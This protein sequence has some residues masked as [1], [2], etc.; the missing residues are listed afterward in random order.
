M[1]PECSL[2]CSQEP[3]TGPYP[4]PDQSSP[5]H[6]ILSLSKIHFNIIPHPRLSLP[7]GLLASGFPTNILYAFLF[8]P[9][10]AICPAQSKNLL[11]ILNLNIPVNTTEWFGLTYFWGTLNIWRFIAYVLGKHTEECITLIPGEHKTETRTQNMKTRSPLYVSIK[12]W[13]KI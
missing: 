13:N 6:H 8:S 11:T 5:Y 7:S 3:S 12:R 10:R 4:E 1:E 9:I 2:P